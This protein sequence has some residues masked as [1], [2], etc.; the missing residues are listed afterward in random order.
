MEFKKMMEENNWS[1][2][3]PAGHLGLSHASITIVMHGLGY[4]YLLN[5]GLKSDSAV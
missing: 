3:D 2:A 5:A 4:I 1:K